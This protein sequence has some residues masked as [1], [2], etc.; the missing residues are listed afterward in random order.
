MEEEAGEEGLLGGGA[1][2]GEAGEE[3]PGQPEDLRRLGGGGLQMNWK[4]G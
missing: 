4:G 3:G 1:V 2:G